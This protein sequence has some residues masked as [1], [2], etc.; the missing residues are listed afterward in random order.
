[1]VQGIGAGALHQASG[2]RQERKRTIC[3]LYPSMCEARVAYRKLTSAKRRASATASSVGMA[4][5]LIRPAEQKVPVTRRRRWSSSLFVH[6]VRGCRVGFVYLTEILLPIYLPLT[7]QDT[8]TLFSAYYLFV[9]SSSAADWCSPAI[10]MSN[11]DDSVYNA[12]L[13]T[14]A[15][16]FYRC[17]ARLAINYVLRGTLARM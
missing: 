9:L 6:Y 11:D 14:A 3:Q 4:E 13:A 10:V 8:A 15:V 17:V 1:M 16:P 2:Q 5:V 7:L 12:L